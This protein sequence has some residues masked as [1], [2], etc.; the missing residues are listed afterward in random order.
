M[1]RL[2]CW[3]VGT[4]VL[5]INEDD[6][7][8]RFM[9]S[10]LAADGFDVIQAPRAVDAI[11]AVA[12]GEPS[13]ILMATRRGLVFE[14]AHLPAHRLIRVIRR[15]TDAP[16]VIIGDSQSADEISSM[17]NGGDVYLPRH[18]SVSELISRCWLLI[19]RQDPS[20]ESRTRPLNAG[21]APVTFAQAAQSVLD[22]LI[23]G[24]AQAPV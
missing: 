4:L 20:L 15:I 21:Y 12:A 10:V 5:V 6:I 24:H 18:Y 16:L 3:A 11:F 13:L 14:A 19:R 2:I 22:M 9:G 7:E 23:G 1:I 17:T 8:R